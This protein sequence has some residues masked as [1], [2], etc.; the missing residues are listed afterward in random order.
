MTRRE[1]R[2]ASKR[3]MGKGRRK[4]AGDSATSGSVEMFQLGNDGNTKKKEIIRVK[5][6]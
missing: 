6:K 2:E 3:R 4:T 1:D 5:H